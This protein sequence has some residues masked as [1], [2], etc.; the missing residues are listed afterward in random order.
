MCVTSGLS[1]LALCPGELSHCWNSVAAVAPGTAWATFSRAH[2]N[3]GAA[4]FTLSRAV[5]P[6]LPAGGGAPGG[7][8]RGEGGGWKGDTQSRKV[9]G[10]LWT[11]G[12]C[13]IALMQ[14]SQLLLQDRGGGIGRDPS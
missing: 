8:G 12:A 11:H 13:D 4:A 2:P 10:K 6:S 9:D 1:M 3:L 7:G 5:E 14:C